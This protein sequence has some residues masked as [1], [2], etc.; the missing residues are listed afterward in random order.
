MTRS[1]RGAS[2]GEVEDAARGMVHSLLRAGMERGKKWRAVVLSRGHCR[3]APQKSTMLGG[4][5]R[6]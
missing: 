6:M 1:A 3:T 2:K 4:C 5:M